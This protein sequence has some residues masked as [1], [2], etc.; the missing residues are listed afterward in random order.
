MQCNPT[1]PHVSNNGDPVFSQ[2][3]FSPYNKVALLP[4]E[5]YTIA[6]HFHK[7]IPS[8][9]IQYSYRSG[10]WEPLI[11]RWFIEISESALICRALVD[12]FCLA[13]LFLTLFRETVKSPLLSRK[14]PIEIPLIFDFP[15]S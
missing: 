9:L 10:Y 4:A 7:A 3:W 15:R 11:N 13:L 14:I 5:E 12:A 8:F 2:L 6:K 1:P